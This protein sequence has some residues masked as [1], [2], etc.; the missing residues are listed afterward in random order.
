MQP[1]NL[2]PYPFR[3]K[4][5]HGEVHIFDE[6]RSKWLVCAPEEW[7]RQ[8]LVMYLI[9]HKGYAKG[10]IGIEHALTLSG[11]T[12]RADIVTFDAAGNPQL[13]VE[14]KAPK[15]KLTEAVFD[16]AVQYNQVLGMPYLAV[17]NGL[18]HH[19]CTWVDGRVVFLEDW[20]AGA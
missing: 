11:I 13:L 1:L 10:R 8:H 17:S 7:V 12:R 4:R 9:H 16:Q 14:C 19:C 18:E 2:P 20:P 5:V 15:I 6:L 3:L